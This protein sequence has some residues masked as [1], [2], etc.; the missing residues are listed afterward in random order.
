MEYVTVI[1][2][3]ILC[4]LLFAF[5]FSDL[6]FLS[7]LNFLNISNIKKPSEKEYFDNENVGTT[8]S[9]MR[10]FQQSIV[11]SNQ[12]KVLTILKSSK[13]FFIIS[14]SSAA[15]NMRKF[16]D[17]PKNTT[18]FYNSDDE[19]YLIKMLCVCFDMPD[20][21]YIKSTKTITIS[22]SP[23]QD[24]Y[25]M[26]HA[27][28]ISLDDYEFFKQLDT[29]GNMC[30]VDYDDVKK[31]R[32]AYFI[33]FI[34]FKGIDF[35]K[36]M[37]KR[38]QLDFIFNSMI[39]DDL[40]WTDLE[41]DGEIDMSA[42]ISKRQRSV[43]VDDFYRLFF[44]FA[45]ENFTQ[46]SGPVTVTFDKP[47]D[48][49]EQML[50]LYDEY[51]LLNLNHVQTQANGFL[52]KGD[53]VFLSNQYDISNNGRYVVNDKGYL[54]SMRTIY[55][56]DQF[57][58][59]K[60]NNQNIMVGKKKRGSEKFN[61]GTFWFEDLQLPG[62]V[63]SINDQI[64]TLIHQK[65]DSSK[66][67][68]CVTNASL[69]TQEVCESAFDEFGHNKL[70]D[71]W[72][73]RCK[74]NTDCPFYDPAKN[75]GTC[76]DNGYCEFPIGVRQ[77]G[78]TRYSGQPY[79]HGCPELNPKCCDGQIAPDYAFSFDALSRSDKVV[80]LLEDEQKQP[81]PL[82]AASTLEIERY[83]DY[84]PD[85]Q[86]SNPSLSPA[87]ELNDLDFQNKYFRDLPSESTSNDSNDS[88]DSIMQNSKVDIQAIQDSCDALLIKSGLT[89]LGYKYVVNPNF[90]IC[91]L[92]KSNV[93]GNIYF[94]V[95]VCIHAPSKS[96]GKVVKY[97]CFFTQRDFTFKFSDIQVI[98]SIFED[99]IELTTGFS[100][101]TR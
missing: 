61:P 43:D 73:K 99:K 59:I 49:I 48:G 18:V 40:I 38:K 8:L 53:V 26:L 51:K 14:Q 46:Q 47:M 71:V 50:N 83:I 94:E 28:L 77:A 92:Y 37:P 80:Q 75:R 5:L 23:S 22:S 86:P 41:D 78:F 15:E 31:D 4:I 55:F 97:K 95:I 98:G 33:P 2:L 85:I 12:K 29:I 60:N 63:F 82:L 70:K 3:F 21:N 101:M 17:L 67:Y 96:K 45:I 87:Q 84:I 35:R 69:K 64:Y 32:V 68:S 90:S 93:V 1:V 89:E 54:E 19:L 65:L 81:Q 36:Y 44:P 25:P 62:N 74:H 88:N 6:R 39:L 72:D 7:K 79:C 13:F 27:K 66:D 16:T 52:R 34:R 76:N 20:F 100:S 57:S 42:I 91:T 11:K 24:P 56:H 10:L 9:F 30:V 58:T